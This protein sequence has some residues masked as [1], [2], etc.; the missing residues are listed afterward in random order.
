MW[1]R[2]VM[3]RLRTVLSETPPG[4][5]FREAPLIRVD[6]PRLLDV[7]QWMRRLVHQGKM[8]PEVRRLAEYVTAD[9]LPGDYAGEAYACYCY[10]LGNRGLTLKDSFGV[11]YTRDPR[12]VEYL[13]RCRELMQRW[14]EDCDGSSVLLAAMLESI[15]NATA[16]CIAAYD[17][18][19]EPT[20]VFPMV[21]CPGGQWRP[22]DTVA[23]KETAKAYRR[24]TWHQIIPV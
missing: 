5:A 15:G 1:H 3:P 24:M 17:G 13:T 7:V 20:H 10:V 8:D 11:R 6:Q 22:L 9:L 19:P 18:N 2:L 23:N 16:F 21:R 12:H 14:A 4:M